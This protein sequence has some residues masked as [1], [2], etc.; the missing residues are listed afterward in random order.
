MDRTDTDSEKHA[1][2][3]VF[4]SWYRAMEDG[5]V[6]GLMA[7][8]T[9]DVVMKPPGAAPILGR[10]AVEQALSAFLD[11]YSETVEYDVEEVEVSGPLAYAR[12]AENAT[13]RAK[14]GSDASSISGFH[15]TILRRQSD[16]NWLIAR[17]ISSLIDNV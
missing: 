10:D 5:D 16:G 3:A 6:A 4:E 8:V 2:R 15:L 11:E 13:L 9:P 14:S 12:I 1:I 17:N 7:L